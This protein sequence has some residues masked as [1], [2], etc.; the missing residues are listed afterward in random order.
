MTETL[1]SKLT[2]AFAPEYIAII[3]ES[4]SHRGHAGWREGGGTHF[5]VEM[6]SAAFDGMGRVARSRAVHRVLREELDGSIHALTLEL[7]GS[8]G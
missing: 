5:R 2:A 8:G 4:E 7:S 3:D 6:R 1:H